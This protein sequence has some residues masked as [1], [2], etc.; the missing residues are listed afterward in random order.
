MSQKGKARFASLTSFTITWRF[1]WHRACTL[2][3]YGVVYAINWGWE[4]IRASAR[5][6][7]AILYITIY[8]HLL[9]WWFRFSIISRSHVFVFSLHWRSAG[10][11][12]IRPFGPRGEP[13]LERMEIA[14]CILKR[15]VRGGTGGYCWNPCL[16]PEQGSGGDILNEW[17]QYRKRN[18]FLMCVTL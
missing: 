7:L 15:G 8:E 5:A 10:I 2:I 1:F 13:T 6:W 14:I 12:L 17:P 4:H 18:T 16:D 3:S 11:H 9:S